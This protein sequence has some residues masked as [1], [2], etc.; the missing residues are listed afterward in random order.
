MSHFAG[1][2]EFSSLHRKAFYV[3]VIAFVVLLGLSAKKPDAIFHPQLWAE[4][5]VIF[6]A[7]QREHGFFHA[8]LTPYAGYYHLVPRVTAAIADAFPLI[9]TPVIYNYVAV[10]LTCCVSY[11]IF[12]V[13]IGLS[14]TYAKFI[15]SLVPV[16]IPHTGE[17]L[18]T[19]TNIQWVLA[20]CLPFLYMQNIHQHWPEMLISLL[21]VLI[22]GLT[23]PFMMFS[24]MAL[25]LRFMYY[26]KF[27]RYEFLFYMSILIVSLV[28][29]ICIIHN[30]DFRAPMSHVS[31]EWT[32]QIKEMF[33]IFFTYFYFGGTL[34][35]HFANIF[36]LFSILL[37][38][39]SFSLLLTLDL[40]YRYY[41]ITALFVA[42]AIFF[43][44]M[45]KI[46]DPLIIIPYGAGSRY[47]YIPYGCVFIAY[48]FLCWSS[49]QWK[50]CF[51]VFILTLVLF[52]SSTVFA[53]RSPFTDFQWRDHVKD[54]SQK[55]TVIVPINPPGWRVELTRKPHE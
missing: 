45:V 36:L 26:R 11:Y 15:L 40:L 54:L 48:I 42:A 46:H 18:V 29:A 28:Q 52:S 13:R 47:Y 9:Y 4:D 38:M 25:L 24:S 33:K 2:N 20:L 8:L 7:Q 21:V 17:V 50:R 14:N 10:L 55:D 37:I 32:Y 44:V 39:I 43:A 23:G 3:V 16:L 53:K 6:L 5:G 34:P 27:N 30:Y 22:I 35:L 51:G 1:V 41:I 31:H 12:F 19:V 49:R